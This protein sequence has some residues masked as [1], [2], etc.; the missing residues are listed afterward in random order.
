VKDSASFARE[1]LARPTRPA[2]KQSGLSAAEV[3]AWEQEFMK[4]DPE[5]T[6]RAQ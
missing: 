3:E 6:D 5:S 1:L 4:R 2:Q